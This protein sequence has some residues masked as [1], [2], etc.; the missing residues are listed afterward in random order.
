VAGLTNQVSNEQ[1]L[2]DYLKRAAVDLHDARQR[3]KA[4]EEREH[5]PIAIVAMSCRY[6]GGVGTPEQLWSL[7]DGAGDAMGDFPTDRGW[8]LSALYHPDPDHHGSYYVRQAGFVDGVTGFD[9]EFFGISP[10]EAASAEPQQRML[11]ELTWEAL[12]RAGIPAEALRGS[13]TGVYAGVIGSEYGPRMQ[14]APE[15]YEGYLLT[16]LTPSVASGRVSYTFGFQGPSFTVDT[17][18]SSSLVAIHLACQALRAGECSL[19]VAGGATVLA[20]PG[21]FIGFSRQ[22]GL[23]ADGRCKSFASAADGTNFAEGG[24]VLLLERLSEARRN[25][26]SVLAVIRGSAVNSDGASNGLTAPNGPSQERVIRAALAQARLA[27]SDVDAVEAHG[28]GTTL[29]DPIEATALLATYG[30]DRDRPLWLGSVKSNIGHTQAGA[31]VAGVI[32]MVQALRH[33]RLPRTL[34]V[35]A[36]SPH[37]DWTAGSVSLLTEPVPWAAGDRQRRFGVSSFGI[38]GANAHVVVEE[39]EPVA[40]PP[41]GPGAPPMPLLLS[42]ASAAGLRAQA[43]LV[44]RVDAAA[45]EV[46][47]ALAT[48]RSG[49]AHRA[50]T[51]E[52]AGLAAL[53]AEQPGAGVFVGDASTGG[54]TAFLFAGQGSQR[55]GMGA[56]LAAEFPVFAAALDEVCGLFELD[57]PLREVMRTGAGGLLDQ[58]AYTQAALFGYEVALYR[59]VTSLGVR[60]DFLA[61]H[62]IGEIAAAHVAGVLDLADAV[63]LVSARGRLMQ[64][65]PAGG[66]MIA[67]EASESELAPML[68]DQPGLSVAALNTPL[69]TVV[70][71]DAG[72]AEA[73]AAHW[74][75]QGRR[76]RRLAVSHA[77][78]SPHMDPMLAAFRAVAGTLTY[79]PP[80]IPVVSDVTGAVATGDQL[81][82]ADYWVG[83]V[84]RA[85]RFTDMVRTL[86][87][88]GVRTFLEIGPDAV[89][90]PAGADTLAE[91]GGDPLLVPAAHRDTPAVAALTTA[92]ARL[93]TRGSTVDWDAVYAGR[94]VRGA[95]LPTYPFQRRHYWIDPPTLTSPGSLGQDATGHPLLAAAVTL[96]TPAIG[97][98]GTV[99]T[100]RVS[101][102]THPWLTDHTIAGTVL[103]PGT[104]LV[105]LAI[106]AGDRVGRARLAELI[107]AAPLLLTGPTDLQVTVGAPDD[108]GR[109]E[110]SVHSRPSEVDDAAWTCH[111]TGMVGPDEPAPEAGAG[112]PWPPRGAQALDVAGL[113]ARLAGHGYHYGPA[114]RLV[115]AAW[116]HG[117][118]ILAE[119]RLPEADQAAG[120]GLHPALLDAAL[121]PLAD[122]ELAAGGGSGGVRVPFSWAGVALHATGAAAVRARIRPGADG[123]VAVDITDPA[124]APVLTAESLTLRELRPDQ[125]ATRP[126]APL[127]HLDWVPAELPDTPP[128]DPSAPAY[129]VVGTGPLAEALAAVAGTSP[130]PDPAAARAAQAGGTVLLCPAEPG[131]DLAAAARAQ[132]ARTLALLQ[133]VLAGDLGTAVVITTGAVAAA[134]GDAVAALDQAPLWG[135][136]RSAQSEH[137]GRVVLLDLDGTPASRA[138]VPAALAAGEPQL[139]LRDGRAHAPRLATGGDALALPAGDDWRLDVT[140]AGTLAN[141]A[142]V[143]SATGAAALEPGQVRIAVRAAA[144]NFRDVLLALGMYPGSAPFGSEAAGVVVEVA[145]DVTDLAVGSR[146]MGLVSGAIAPLAVTDRRLVTAVPT[147]WSYAQAAAA[148]I[149]FMTAYHGLVDLAGL[150]AGDTV[151]VH[152]AAGGVGMAATRLARVLGAEVYGTAS[153]GKWGTL[154]AEGFSG[155]RIGSSRD[156]SFVD[157]FAGRGFDVVL[158]SLSGEF[159][160]A[161]AGLLAAGG[162]FLEMGKTDIRDADAMH[163]AHPGISYRAFDLNDAGP[164]HHAHL[165]GVLGELFESGRVA[166]LPVTGWDVRQARDAFR[167]LSQARHVGK[168]VLALPRALDPAGSVLVTGGTGGLG[169]QIARHLADRHGVRHLVLASRR[170]AAADGAERLRAELAAAG[171]EV[172]LA[173]CDTADR[174]ALAALLA[175]IPAEHPLTGV[176]HLAGTLD[177]VP[178]DRLTAGQLDATMRSKVDGAAALAELTAGADLAA[179]VLFSSL[180]GT[181]GNPGQ[182][183]YAAANTFLD[184]L[185]AHRHRHGRPG[186][187]L[188]WGPWQPVGG[189]TAALSDADRARIARSGVL[190]LSEVDG[191][192][193]LDAALAAGRPNAVPAAL[194]LSVLRTR[195]AAGELPPLLRGLV[196]TSTRRAAAAGVAGVGE[197]RERLAGMSEPDRR[198]SLDELVR[199]QVAAVLGHGAGELVEADRAFATLGFDSLTAVELRNRLNTATGLRLPAT[200]LFDHPTAAALTAFLRT[201]LLGEAAG[202]LPAPPVRVSTVDEPVAIV[203]MACRYPGGVRGPEDLWRLVRTG[204]DAIGDFPSDRGWEL[205]TLYDP[206]PAR[207]GHSYTRHG[208]FLD[209][210]DEFD[211]GLFRLSPRE[212][213]ATDPQQRLLLETTW[214]LF[215]RAG[216]DPTSLSGSRTG[217]FAGVIAGEYASRLRSVPPDVE[218]FLITGNTASVASGRLAYTFG[219]E[220]PAVTVDTACSSSLVA[221]H[222]ACQSLRTGECDLAVAGGA[223]VMATPNTFIE[224]SRQ[225]GLSPDGRC[226][227]FGAGADGT[228]WG[229]GAGVLLLERLSDARRHGHPVLALVRGSAVNQDGASNGLSAPNG[230]SQQR[231]IRQALAA[232]G[233]APSDVD[234]V[235]AHGTGTALGDPIEAQAL[236][237]TYGR[238]RDPAAPLWLGSIKSNIGHTLAAAAVA[239]VIKMVMAM[240]HGELPPTL[241]AA[242]PSPHVD[243]SAGAVSLLHAARPWQPGRARRAGVS[244]FGISG[245]NA[246]ALL[247]Q[248]PDADPAGAAADPPGDAPPAVAWVLSGR[249]EGALRDQAAGL[250]RYAQARPELPSRDIAWSLGTGRA[251]LEHRAVVVDVDRA[252]LLA[253]LRAAA[254]GAQAANLVTG[255]GFDPKP[256]VF[257]FPGQG[258]QWVGMARALLDTAPVFRDRVAACAAALAPHT[259]WSLIEALRGELPPSTLARVDVVQPALWAVMVS[260]AEL[261]RSYGVTPAAVV[262]HSQGEIAAAAVAGALSLDAAAAVVAL[263]SRAVAALAAGA[264][265]MASVAAPED[266]VREL[267]ARWGGDLSVAAVNGP[268][269]TVVS[270]TPAAVDGILAAA[271]RAGLRARRVPVDYASHSAQMDGLR[272]RLL[273]DLAGITPRPAGLAYYSATTGGLLDTS[274]LDADYWFTNLRE[275]VRFEAATRALLEHGHRVFIEASPHPVLTVGIGETIEAAGYAGGRSPAVALGSLR[276]DEGGL[277]RFLRSAGEAY[278]HGLAVDWPAALGGGGRVELPTYPFQR[279]RYWL[280]SPELPSDAAGLGLG[281]AGHPLLAAV[282]EDVDGA[283]TALSGQVSTRALPWLADHA[284]AGTTLLPGTAFV[285]MALR[286]AAEAGRDRVDELTLEAP[287]VLA[288]DAAAD[289]RLSVG[290]A[291]PTGQRPL[292]IHSR[293]SH[294]DSPDRAWTRHASGLLGTGGP[295]PDPLTAWPPPGATPVDTAGA[296]DTLADVGLEYGPAF[297]GLRA[298]WRCGAEVYAEV[299]LPDAAGGDGFGL[300]PA[301]LDAALHALALARPAG[302]GGTVPLPFGWTG[303]TLARAGV[304]ALRVRL[305]PAGPDAVAVTVADDTGRPVA[306]VESLTVRDTPVEALRDLRTDLR[307]ALYAVSWP[308]AEPAD[309]DADAPAGPWPVLG[310]ATRFAGLPVTAYSD[311]P[312]LTVGGAGPGGPEWVLTAVPVAAG[313]PPAA[314]RTATAHV[315]GLLQAW[316]ADERVGAA[317]L[318]VTTRGAVQTGVEGEPAPDLAAAA[319]AGLVRTAQAEQP[320][321]YVL[322]D[323]DEHADSVAAIPAALRTGEPQLAIR[324]GTAHVPR[325]APAA[326]HGTAPTWRPHGTVVVTGG[327]GVLGSLIARHLAGTGGVRHLL[328]L[329]RRGPDAPGAA[330]LAAELERLG[331]EVTLAACDTGDRADLAAVLAGV[332]AEHPVTGVVHAAGV[333]DDGVLATLTPGRLDTVLRPKLDAAW[334]LHELTRDRELD[335]FVLFSSFAGLAGSPGQGNYAAANAA[336]DALAAVRAA[337]GRPAA[338]LAWGLWADSSGLTEAADTARIRRTGLLPLP[339]ELGLALFDRALAAGAPLL[340]PVRV[341][342]SVLRTRARGGTLPPLFAGLVR[343]ADRRPGSDGN[344]DELARR[345]AGLD[346]DGQD[347]VLR[348]LLAATLAA[349]LGHGNPGAVELDRTFTELGLDSLTGLE[350]RNRLTAATGLRLP[351]TLVFDYPTPA[352][353]AGY[354]RAELG[355]GEPAAPGGAV[356]LDALEASVGAV[357]DGDPRRAVIA[358]RLRAILARLDT[359]GA[360]GTDRLAAAT[361]GEIFDFIDNELGRAVR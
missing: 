328:L 35:D 4:A 91:A 217:V 109:C 59:L 250:L 37:V 244:S 147:G 144:L 122:T 263:R 317:R 267:A 237:A 47:Y 224:F 342:G 156:L 120:F 339:A 197:L 257:V 7:V 230:P 302:V 226:K 350:L 293:P 108:T 25:G 12:E 78:H 196:R 245:T 332:P 359:A 182:A 241:H 213:L 353:L 206:D 335:A 61:G 221:L 207:T 76:T 133:E 56:E 290:A 16:G 94:A 282:V 32:K 2:R 216:I 177:D 199:G 5:E 344:A 343:A 121:H 3:L 284:V 194:D 124:G 215:E 111:A 324:A 275:T 256:V 225:R 232:A 167:Y 92:L 42:A 341:D 157:T 88:A 251:A 44:S 338:S 193:L 173:A 75:A 123:T 49:L 252:G 205:D 314:A 287:L 13:D 202:A 136:A 277:D 222:L 192:A 172:T 281:V 161:S 117:G 142:L 336:L 253:G 299:V 83:H 160:D 30:Q 138:A 129:A 280:E 311:L 278:A 306:A 22:R 270:G 240:R 40:D 204:T 333:L 51:V 97:G 354:L 285:D 1:R 43:E 26:H 195:A 189:M 153:A 54:R 158:N 305:R 21:V 126:A 330:E 36:P 212:A 254:A 166:P 71:G 327:T 48:G 112:G 31:G 57:E 81:V 154:R 198:R 352:G 53:A 271:E 80:T 141:L 179:F 274:A 107:L 234:A 235:E 178:L 211:A 84:R 331:A 68:A 337:E 288:D 319:V 272:D 220:G 296:Y 164:D 183:N 360:G 60:P 106:H 148:P 355:A 312:T 248:A 62:S 152:A 210:A 104:A 116:R 303:V 33:A 146:V 39:A 208:G 131:A 185:A 50:A 233:L 14:H 259:D 346:A 345:L 15:A 96:A 74:Q 151:L 295:A 114:F 103:V 218:G 301:L 313:E 249:D 351:A 186:T 316:Q 115:Q 24:G 70:A 82:T 361:A 260:L 58:T 318:V 127:Y 236:L 46:A 170:G 98:A 113:Y 145:P 184:A 264:G 29:G 171:T 229:E 300:H 214:E 102:G 38:S 258:S 119:L 307:N 209:G 292:T 101:P 19:A 27:P 125:L 228:G 169:Q 203:A 325:L 99:L 132:A 163:A 41:A 128:P 66:A 8:D 159:V 309:A 143:P 73:V 261:W 6:P 349:V 238:D 190:P 28:T 130:Y 17:A 20:S 11:L 100:G 86:H 187:A 134:P 23:A 358:A 308:A 69:S 289:L 273:A 223:T 63:T 162:R 191:L 95:E 227:A 294:V 279:E 347:Q 286:A 320:G 9:A 188:A 291:L 310:D 315:L 149:A 297:R 247:E 65:Q 255:V 72:A 266:A 243:W 10:R 242:E 239:G 165:L 77:F 118:E 219:L 140:E 150:A 176:L 322:L 64:A 348:E 246:H 34:H 326:V 323:L 168:V 357:P 180:A 276:R 79:H 181:A 283:T 262:G 201:E 304:S 174:D 105:E 340:A 87:A 135:L 356:D 90:A 52:P 155:D 110:L 321:A 137:P 269:S 268:R 85:V 334:H 89:L 265:G 298:A 45:P 67:V 329:G 175:G 231:V 200:L 139:A 93:W 18:C 55:A